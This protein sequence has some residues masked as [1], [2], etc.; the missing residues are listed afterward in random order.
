MYTPDVCVLLVWVSLRLHGLTLKLI[1][2]STLFYSTL[3]YSILFYSILFSFT[4]FVLFL[5]WRVAGMT[6]LGST[7]RYLSRGGRAAWTS[8]KKKL[9]FPVRLLPP[10]ENT[11]CIYLFLVAREFFSPRVQSVIHER[12]HD[13][14]TCPLFGRGVDVNIS[15]TVKVVQYRAQGLGLCHWLH[16]HPNC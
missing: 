5:N 9:Y 6:F 7:Q 12:F 10:I 8:E 16:T 2:F 11:F 3:L 4:T 14:V 1:F 15:C 13:E